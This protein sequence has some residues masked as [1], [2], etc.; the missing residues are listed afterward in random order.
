M[1]KKRPD[2]SKEYQKEL[3]LLKRI[4]EAEEA[5]LDTSFRRSK[6]EI[7]L[8]N[9]LLKQQ[10]LVEVLRDYKN[11]GLELTEKEQK[12]YD[13]TLNSLKQQLAVEKQALNIEKKRVTTLKL[14]QN[15]AVGFLNALPISFFMEADASMK[16]INK[17][18][19]LSGIRAEAMRTNIEGA[20]ISA[21]RLGANIQDLSNIQSTFA[22]ET[23]RA[24]A[25]TEEAQM[26]IVAIGKGTGLGVEQAARLTG[27]FELMGL[28]AEKSAQFV[29]GVVDSSERMGV[30]T[31]KVL[32]NI[33]EN[34]KDL[35]KFTF[36]GGIQGFAEMASYAEKFKVDMGSMLD[37]AERARTLEGAVDLAA[38]LQV[39]GGEFAKS[40]PFK[41]LFLSRND[42][43]E[44]TKKI[45]DMTKSVATFKKNADGSFETF[46]S[47][48]DM[49]R[50]ER[51][52][53]SLGMQRGEL[54]EQAK[55]MAEIRRMRQQM[56]GTTLTK[57]EMESIEG[58]AK[59]N[60]DTGK[61]FVE[62]N[63]QKKDLSRI[64]AQDAQLIEQQ[65][66]T[67]DQRAKDAQTFDEVFSNTVTMF[68]SSMLPILDGMNDILTNVVQP[69]VTEISNLL[70]SSPSWVTSI[71]KYG[72]AI[73]G[74]LLV[75]SKTASM[76][77]PIMGIFKGG[78]ISKLLSGGAKGVGGASAIGG[79]TGG[80]MSSMGAGAGVGVAAAGMGTGIML[81][82]KGFAELATAMK[83]LDVNQL[84]AFKEV[85]LGLSVAIPAAAI[86][87]GVLA[88]VAAPAAPP[89]LA[90]GAAIGLV[91]AGVGGA[92]IGIGYLVDG[93]SSLMKTASPEKI[94]KTAAGISTLAGASLMF[95]NPLAV[96]GLGTMAS[97]VLAMSSA[98]SGMEKIGYAFEKIETV[99]Q[100]STSQFTEL[101]KTIDAIQNMEIDTNS[102][103]GSLA[104][105]L[106]KPIMVEFANKDVAINTRVNL[107]V[108][109]RKLAESLNIPQ[110]VA[111]STYDQK[112][113]KSGGSTST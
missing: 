64:T 66:R 104:N 10:A 35:Q 24:K 67:L 80:F 59:F 14:L 109:G 5:S 47:P 7:N 111:V 39:M 2:F 49:D 84:E 75:A 36:R 89:L 34:F 16:S 43:A 93:F 96:L 31:N 78:G 71:M 101:R 19:G 37:S 8:Q 56:L 98:G 32:K 63:G 85:T 55:R 6:A 12:L 9:S 97:S 70:N 88:A 72:G 11:K 82:A 20:S 22:D 29:Q 1:A 26:A 33:T 95:A 102:A 74:G 86:A 106:N 25:L 58:M 76:L 108:D 65:A 23:G 94:M 46:I 61:F 77:S 27:Q 81:A 28:N 79:N 100:G 52:G 103:F 18:L 110:R 30:N 87:I 112:S 69:V 83:G 44:F 92:A 107:N 42:P 57:D 38:E 13:S 48:M 91:G 21:A 41:L 54:V 113:G 15:A 68:K 17:E 60:S 90:F 51:V 3:D 40:D 4:Q 62:I 73:A 45:N 50:L 53:E 99:L 105:L